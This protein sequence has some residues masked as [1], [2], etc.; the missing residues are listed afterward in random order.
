MALPDMTVQFAGV[1]NTV[2]TGMDDQRALY[3]KLFS[4]EVITAFEAGTV[5]LDKHTVRTISAGKSAQFPVLGRT[6]A[7]S[8]HEPGTAIDG[9]TQAQSERVI[10]VDKLL[11][12]SLFMADIDDALSH[13]DIRGKYAAQMG[14]KLALT[15]D[16]HVMRE[17]ILAARDTATVTGGDGGFQV[18]DD[19]LDSATDD[20]WLKA[21]VD[22]LYA[23]A[24][25]FDNKFVTG[26]RYCL[27]KPAT[28]RRLAQTVSTS[29]FSVLH[30]DYGVTEGSFSAGE[31]PPIAGIQIISAP[32]LP[33]TDST[34]E[35]FHGVDATKTRGIV[36][37]S[38]A[39]GTVKLMDLS[40]QSQ[41]MIQNQG[42]LMVARYAMG[43]GILAPEC[44]A[45]ILVVT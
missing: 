12:K 25:N 8:Y 5:V 26:P 2:N 44:A 37:T 39:V 23:C 1:D 4:G 35:E 22:A 20:T 6:G 24:V 7:A 29:G 45:E 32:T 27:V 14:H 21:W 10:P 41:W 40:L 36:F 38:D 16:N 13:F 19:N 11:I 34:G 43:H 42:T 15:F 28:Y 33:S 31:I 3:L 17:I 18:S 30:R 9:E